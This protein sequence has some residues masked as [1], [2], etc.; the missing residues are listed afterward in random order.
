VASNIDLTT[1]DW[2]LKDLYDEARIMTAVCAENPAYTRTKKIPRFPERKHSFVVHYGSPNRSATFTRAQGNRYPSKGLELQIKRGHDYCIGRID[3]ETMLASQDEPDRLRNAV[4]GE[5][6][7]ALLALNNSLGRAFFGNGS[8]ALGLINQTS[9]DT[10]TLT[11]KDPG[12][13]VHFDAGNVLVFAADDAS[14]LRDSGATLTVSKVNE[15]AGTLTMS[16]KLNTISGLASGDSIFVQGDYVTAAD[17]L[18]P[19]GLDAWVPKTAPTTT[20]TFC[21]A[22][23]SVNVTKLAGH[24]HTS[25]TDPGLTTLEAVQLL[26]T[27]IKRSGFSADTAYLGTDRFRKLI[28]ELDAKVL[29]EKEVVPIHGVSGE[30]IA[31]VGFDK[32]IVHAGG[33]IVSVFPERNCPED[34]A[35]VLRQEVV[36]FLSLGQA[37]RWVVT[38]TPVSDADQTEFRLAYWGNFKVRMPAAVGR[39]D[40]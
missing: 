37:P 2:A 4:E 18:L 32:V 31:E 11:L 34:T 26:S 6:D 19:N 24:R 39:Y 33:A 40:W 8:G 38:G 21:N 5:A 29:Y 27:R 22:D 20:E 1:F 14:S 7:N 3:T 9:L 13:V 30:I 28:T 16:A 35:W 25:T 23:R 36:E 15:S 10:T 12:D 17:K